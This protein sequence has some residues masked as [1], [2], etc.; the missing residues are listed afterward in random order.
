MC[1]LSKYTTSIQTS[2]ALKIILYWKMSYAIK[3]NIEANP[4]TA[5]GSFELILHNYDVLLRFI[6]ILSECKCKVNSLFLAERIISAYF[7]ILSIL[8]PQSSSSWIWAAFFCSTVCFILRSSL[9][10]SIFY[11]PCSL[12]R[13]AY[14]SCICSIS[15]PF[16]SESCVFAYKA[17]SCKL[18]GRALSVKTFAQFAL[19]VALQ[20]MM[21]SFS[22]YP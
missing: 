21:C 16:S 18:I 10:T 14:D 11:S 15:V 4:T 19:A 5:A 6:M 7:N 20:D 1:T 3:G 8:Y 13:F 17:S 2:F 9:M 22:F 12:V